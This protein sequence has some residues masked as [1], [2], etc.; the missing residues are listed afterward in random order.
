[1]KREFNYSRNGVEYVTVNQWVA[2]RRKD[3]GRRH[4]VVGKLVNGKVIPA[5]YIGKL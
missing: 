2:T 4:P 3:G 1:M 5:N